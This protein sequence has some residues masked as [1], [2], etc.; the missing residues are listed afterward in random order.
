MEANLS[1]ISDHNLRN[2]CSGSR[3]GSAWVSRVTTMF[4]KCSDSINH[5]KLGNKHW[6]VD[7]VSVWNSA[8]SKELKLAYLMWLE[9]DVRGHEELSDVFL[10]ERHCQL[11]LYCTHDS[12]KRSVVHTVI[13]WLSDKAADQLTDQSA[14]PKADLTWFVA[15]EIPIWTCV[16]GSWPCLS[17][18]GE[19]TPA[20]C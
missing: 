9:G 8:D 5:L 18:Q 10:S 13:N 6:V 15:N 14:N 12:I 7:L 20:K 17:T 3:S 1:R 11:I 19:L 16:Q 4:L 2:C